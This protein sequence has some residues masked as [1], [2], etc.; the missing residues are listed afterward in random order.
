VQLATVRGNHPA[1]FP[2][3]D[4]L[5]FRRGVFGTVIALSKDISS[6]EKGLMTERRAAR[7]YDLSFSAIVRVPAGDK[8]VQQP[9]K[10]RNISTR[11]VYLILDR[12]VSRDTDIDLNMVLPTNTSGGA[13]IFV[14]AM[15][16]VVRVEEW[17]HDRNHRVGVAA[18]IRRYE[19]VR[20]DPAIPAPRTL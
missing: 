17:S 18:V 3:L 15:G 6:R 19:I 7:R 4:S 9:G 2:R 10:T 11:G 1:A 12:A 8:G 14:R 20:S 16:R 5:I 13:S